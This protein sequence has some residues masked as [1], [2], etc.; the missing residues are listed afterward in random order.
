VKESGSIDLEEFMS[1]IVLYN[2]NQQINE[3]ITPDLIQI[4]LMPPCLRTLTEEG[5][6]EG[7]RDNGLLN[8]AIFYRKSS[9][10]D[11]RNKLHSHNKNYVSPPLESRQIENIIRSVDARQY[12]YT[13]D[14]EPICSFCDRKTCLTLQFGVGYKPW[15]DGE[16]YDD[17]NIINLRKIL[18]DPPTYLL[19]IDGSDIQ[20]TSAEFS[21]YSKFKKRILELRNKVLRPVKQGQWDMRIR[22]LL[23]SLTEIEAP[24]DASYEGAILNC[25]NEFLSKFNKSTRETSE[26]DLIRGGPVIIDDRVFFPVD[27]LHK[28]L[29]S[30]K[31]S[32]SQEKLFA[33]LRKKECKF[34][35][36]TLKGK[37]M[38]IWSIPLRFVNYQT[39]DFT[40]AKF[41][42]EGPEI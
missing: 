36:R 42:Q 27:Y 4:D 35:N 3:T 24:E 31:L 18:T 10:S 38:S 5:L 15:E 26:E 34:S 33:I 39:E 9:P 37:S 20:L 7:V 28:Y 29:G 1:S 13:C 25:V 14:R 19:E 41:E 40:P 11:W 21:E 8:F 30:Q 22:Q 23:N 12:Q 2:G 32:I 17:P 16:S 6:V